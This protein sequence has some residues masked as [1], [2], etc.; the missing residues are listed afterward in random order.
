[1][2]GPVTK[3]NINGANHQIEIDHDGND[4]SY[5]VEKAKKLW[6]ETKPD[7]KTHAAFGYSTQLQLPR[8]GATY[9]RAGFDYNE[10]PVVDR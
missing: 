6:D 8:N 5:V 3:V 7:S 2:G 10:Q 1:M 4:L 9:G